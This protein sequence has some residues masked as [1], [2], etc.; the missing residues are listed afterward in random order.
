MYRYTPAPQ[1][2]RALYSERKYR[3]GT[4]PG[5]VALYFSY[6]TEYLACVNFHK[7][8]EHTVFY[9]GTEV[10]H[11]PVNGYMFPVNMFIMKEIQL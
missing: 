1:V 5:V 10:N 11:V 3:R 7:H 9:S 6:N 8:F 2:L 4:W